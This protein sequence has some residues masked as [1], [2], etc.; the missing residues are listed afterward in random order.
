VG[1]AF[2]Q[3]EKFPAA[4]AYFR[5]FPNEPIVP[6]GGG[7]G[8]MTIDQTRPL[9]GMTI[10]S[11]LEAIAASRASD[12]LV[13]VEGNQSSLNIPIVPGGSTF[14]FERGQSLLSA[15]DLVARGQPVPEMTRTSLGMDDRA[16]RQ[17]ADARARVV[18]LRRLELRGCLVGRPDVV[19]PDPFGG[20]ATT[21][22]LLGI[23]RQLFRA[24]HVGGPLRIVYYASFRTGT[25]T[26]TES[27]W[28]EWQSRYTAAVVDTT[29]HGRFAW[30]VAPFGDY[31][32]NVMAESQLAVDDWVREHVGAARSVPRPIPIEGLLLGTGPR[33]VAFP[34][35]QEFLRN[36]RAV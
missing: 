12:V 3:R 32:M 28:R 11:L 25:P 5:T 27:V 8:R 23:L 34:Q 24:D 18:G 31:Q 36:L 4:P 33:P 13:A 10:L 15:F 16:I 17:V 7:G 14:L 20:G 26:A 21:Y 29:P 9:S 22:D 30:D 35:E 1:T 19:R 6:A 2:I